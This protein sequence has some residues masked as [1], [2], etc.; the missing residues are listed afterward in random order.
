[1]SVPLRPSRVFLAWFCRTGGV[2]LL[3]ALV[4]TLV[5]M[6]HA[7]PVDPTWI[8]GLYDDGDGDDIVL[9]VTTG[10]VPPIPTW[11]L[12]TRVTIVTPIAAE[13]NLDVRA[14]RP[15]LASERAP[16]A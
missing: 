15:R 6:A 4:L 1:V 2:G 14:P 9:L 13:A 16:P 12:I 3:V 8:P 7:S 10:D 5:P 11:D